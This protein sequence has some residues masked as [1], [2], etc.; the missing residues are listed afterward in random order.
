LIELQRVRRTC[1]ADIDLHCKGIRPGEGRILDCLA[2]KEPA[3]LPVCKEAV[4][5]AR[6]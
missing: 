2:A 1:M 5:Q 3:L 6:R 4:L